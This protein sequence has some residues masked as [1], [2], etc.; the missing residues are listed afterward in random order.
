MQAKMPC[1]GG[2]VKR[3]RRLTADPASYSKYQQVGRALMRSADDLT[4]LATDGD[5][6]GNAIGIVAIHAGIAYADALCIRFGGFKSGAGDH[7][8]AV[9]AVKE[10]LGSRVDD[11]AV[12]RLRR[13][14]A[15]KDQ[16][17]YRGDY[18]T[19]S[20]ARQLVSDAREFATLAEDLLRHSPFS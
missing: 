20:D 18:Y 2:M 15:E 8:R 3:G 6:Y 16:I 4:G 12:R 14:L 5:S 11:T 9:D 7:L 19:V 13:I 1:S 10:A 17:S